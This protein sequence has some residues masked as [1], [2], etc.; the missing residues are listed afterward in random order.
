MTPIQQNA[1]A[2][3]TA[4]PSTP[5]GR[6]IYAVGD[7]HGRFDALQALH[8]LILADLK[9]SGN[10][11][12]T[13]V[14][15][16]D[17]LD[18]GK[19]SYDVI[20]DLVKAPLKGFD[21]HHL[22]GNHERMA[23]D[24]LAGRSGGQSWLLN[25]GDVTL[26]SYGIRLDGLD[27]LPANLRETFKA[28]IPRTHLDFL[29][30]LKL[31]FIEGDYLFVHAGIRPNIALENQDEKDLLWIRD[32]FLNATKAFEK[33]VVHG[34]T[35]CPTPEIRANRIGI[36][37]GAYKTG[38]LSCLVLDGEDRRILQTRLEP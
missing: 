27:T 2:I 20:N 9:A 13:L 36:D 34:H 26:Q 1:A 35:I 17:Y 14:Y 37:T 30:R 38:R 8:Q 33:M 24:F 15:L 28:T 22:M 6:R 29:H 31:F 5:K 32:S 12:N 10:R 18:R 19:Q 25:G 7:I 23:L 16:G 21:I 3:S 11:W 4:C